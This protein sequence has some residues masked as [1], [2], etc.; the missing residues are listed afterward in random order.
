MYEWANAKLNEIALDNNKCPKELNASNMLS[1]HAEVLNK[2]KS[3]TVWKEI[4]L[5]LLQTA[6]DEIQ[7]NESL[8]YS[9]FT[10]DNSGKLRMVK[11][12]LRNTVDYL[13]TALQSFDA[14]RVSKEL[15][16]AAVAG[17]SGDMHAINSTIIASA[18]GT[19]SLPCDALKQHVEMRM[20]LG[21]AKQ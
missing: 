12:A 9:I 15:A 5:D 2:A 7:S 3:I 14:A 19:V 20:T 11:D 1:K 18:W 17:A 6:R 10:N 13:N 4:I 16:L 21:K 8:C